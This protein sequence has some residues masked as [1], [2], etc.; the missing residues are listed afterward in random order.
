MKNTIYLEVPYDVNVFKKG[1]IFKGDLT[2]QKT[3]AMAKGILFC[4]KPTIETIFTCV[5]MSTSHLNMGNWIILQPTFKTKLRY[6][7]QINLFKL[8]KL[9]S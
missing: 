3:V 7:F 6:W 4:D 8:Y 1:Y 9:I 5:E 2:E